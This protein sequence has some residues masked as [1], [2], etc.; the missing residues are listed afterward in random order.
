MH[1]RGNE[2]ILSKQQL[3]I[4]RPIAIFYGNDW[5]RAEIVQNIDHD[6]MKVLLGKNI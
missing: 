5:H 6:K 2:H 4:G 1:L 3:V